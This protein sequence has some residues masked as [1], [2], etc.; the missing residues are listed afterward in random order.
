MRWLALAVACLAT[1]FGVADA[2]LSDEP[3]EAVDGG[4]SVAAAPD[5]DPDARIAMQVAMTLKSDPAWGRIG[6]GKVDQGIVWLDGT[7]SEEGR[8]ADALHVIG[9]MDG[10]RGIRNGVRVPS[11]LEEP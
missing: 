10:V 8:L 6:V 1:G 11:T 3:D 9:K 2:Q 7:V 4:V 5:T